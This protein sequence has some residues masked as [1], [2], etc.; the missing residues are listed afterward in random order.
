MPNDKTAA[1]YILIEH[2]DGNDP[3]VIHVFD[4]PEER[5]KATR[6]AILGPDDDGC[7]LDLTELEEDGHMSF[8]GD[9]PLSWLRAFIE[10][11]M[12]GGQDKGSYNAYEVFMVAKYYW[13]QQECHPGNSKPI[14]YYWE[15][16]LSTLRTLRSAIDAE[17]AADANKAV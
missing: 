17:R 5:I 11:N 16:A 15:L 12:G 1:K 3:S 8:E 9:P 10:P 2:N 13:S 14:S 7:I 4:T 6:E